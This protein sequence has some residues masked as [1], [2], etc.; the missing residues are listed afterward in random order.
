MRLLVQ[1]RHCNFYP[2][3]ECQGTK[4]ELITFNFRY[5]YKFSEVLIC[6]QSHPLSLNDNFLFLLVC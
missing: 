3:V 6:L 1:E 4:S 2:A 5:K